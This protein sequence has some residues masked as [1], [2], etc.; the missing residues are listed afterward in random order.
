MSKSIELKFGVLGGGSISGQ[1][2]QTIASQINNIVNEIERRGITNL[3]F[4]VDP[5]A[6]KIIRTQLGAIG[7]TRNL[8]SGLDKLETR[9]NSLGKGF[10]NSNTQMARGAATALSEMKK[11][12]VDIERLRG[13]SNPSKSELSQLEQL[14]KQWAKNYSAVEKYISAVNKQ[15]AI[16]SDIE[17]KGDKSVSSAYNEAQQFYQYGSLGSNTAGAT[18]LNAKMTELNTTYSTYNS[19]LEKAQNKEL[20][21]DQEI[22][23]LD[24]CGIKIKSLSNEIRNLSMSASRDSRAGLTFGEM[25]SFSS[26]QRQAKAVANLKR[27]YGD[28]INKNAEL[29]SSF[30]QLEKSFTLNSAGNAYIGF[31]N[32]AKGAK[33]AS[34]AVNN[35]RTK[36]DEAGI[37]SQSFIYKTK[38][39]FTKH[40]STYIAMAGVTLAM[41]AFQQLYENV[42]NVDK[43]M[44]ELKKVTN[45]TNEAYN[46][47]LDSAIKKSQALGA[48]V[49]DYVNATADFAR[50]GYTI[51]ESDALA[52]A[53]TVYKNVGDGIESIDMASESIIATMKAFG[54]EAIEAMDIIDAFNEVGNNFAISSTGIGEAITRSASSLFT[55]GNTLAESIA[56]ITAAN[57]SVQDP[58]KVGTTLKTVTMFLRAAKDEAEDAGESTEGMA[59][60]VSELRDSLLH[61]TDNKVDIMIDDSTFKSTTQILRELSQVWDNLTDVDRANILEKI[62]GKRNSNVVSSLITNFETVEEVLATIQTDAGSAMAEQEKWLDSI[63]GKTNQFKSSFESLST[64]VLDS[65]LVKGIVS[66]GTTIINALDSVFGFMDGLLVKLPLV[67]VAVNLAGKALTAFLGSKFF[68][69]AL[70]SNFIQTL[71]TPLVGAINGVASAGLTA[72]GVFGGLAEGVKIAATSIKASLAAMGPVGWI[73]L[74]A[75]AVTVLISAFN[76]AKQKSE[77]A[78]QAAEESAKTYQDNANSLDEYSNKIISL[79]KELDAGNLSE[80]EAYNKRQELIEIQKDLIEKYGDESIAINTLTDDINEQ[81]EAFRT[82]KEEKWEDWKSSH[83]G[84]AQDAADVMTNPADKSS[85]LK[86]GNFYDNDRITYHG[87]DSKLTEKIM[88][89]VGMTLGVNPNDMSQTVLLF[90]AEDTDNIYSLIEAYQ[91]LFTIVE[92]YKNQVANSGGDTEPYDELLT[93]I[94]GM[95]SDLEAF[96]KENETNFNT[97]AEG[98][99]SFNKEY[100]KTWDKVVAAQKEYDDA[101][102]GGDEAEILSAIEKMNAAE[103]AFSKITVNDEAVALYAKRYFEKFN[104]ETEKYQV[105]LNLI[106]DDKQVADEAKKACDVF[107]NEAGKIDKYEI[108]NVELELESN[109]NSNKYSENKE[110][111]YKALKKAADEY[112]IEVADLIDILAE[113]GLI[114]LTTTE[115]NNNLEKSFSKTISTLDSMSG[116]GSSINSI[117][118]SMVGGEGLQFNDLSNLTDQMSEFEMTTEE[119]DKY[120]KQV[121]DAQGSAAEMQQVF[122]DLTN[123]IIS[124]KIAAGELT[125]EHEDLLALYLKQCGVANATQVAH[126][127]LGGTITITKEEYEL[128]SDELKNQV[129]A[130]ETANG[131]YEIEAEVIEELGGTVDTMSQIIAL[132]QAGITDVTISNCQARVEALKKEAEA[133]LKIQA[134]IN[135]LNTAMPGLGNMYGT[136]GTLANTL[137]DKLGMGDYDVAGTGGMTY[138]EYQKSQKAAEQ[139]KIYEDALK[140]LSEITFDGGGGSNSGDPVLDAWNKSVAEQKHLLEMD[141]QTKEEYY[142]W[143]RDNYKKSLGDAEKYADEIRSIEEE[144]YNWEK[145]QIAE[146]VALKE[147]Q[148]KNDLLNGKKDEVEYQR[149][150]VDTYKDAY[151]EIEENANLYGVDEKERLDALNGYLDKEKSA[152]NALYEEERDLLEHKLA[153]NLISE[154]MYLIELTRLYNKYY[155]GQE[156]YAEE[157][158]EKREELF[159]KQN[160]VMEKWAQ[161]AADAVESIA[162]AAEDAVSAVTDLIEGSIDAHEENFNLEKGLLDHALAMNYIS[163]EEYYNSLESLYKKYF[164]DKYIYMEQYWENQEEVYQHEQEMLEESASAVED[165]HAKVVDMIKQELEDAIESIEEAKEKYLDLIDIRREALNEQ[166]DEEDY[167]KERDEQIANISELQRQ[168]NALANDTSAEGIRKYKEVY[169]Q[170][171]EAE[172]ALAEFEREHTYEQMNDELDNEA[173]AV[174]NRLDGKITEYEKL[175]DDNVYLVE[176]AWRRMS[177]MNTDLY[178]QLAEHNAKHTTSIKDDL[179]DAWNTATEAV[180]RYN[181][182]QTGYKTI[183]EQIG[184]PGMDSGEYDSYAGS[185]KTKQT[186]NWVEIAGTFGAEMLG[187]GTS[188]LT[189]FTGILDAIFDSPATKLLDMGAGALSAF[190]QS[191]AS[192]LTTILGLLGG[193]AGGTSYVPKTGMYL[194]DELGEELKLI[195]N[196]NGASYTMLTR[197]SKVITNEATER[198]MKLVSNPDLLTG[199]V[200]KIKVADVGGSIPTQTINNQPTSIQNTFYIQSNTPKE[201]ASEIEKLMPKIASYTIG[202]MVNGSNNLGIKRK[203]QHLY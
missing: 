89:E 16:V 22:A 25:E 2:G 188:L 198:L 56:L 80:Q 3:K 55:A 14:E 120:T 8:T 177:D 5:A 102:L 129:K 165:I 27:L 137:F 187:V 133:Y 12:I 128:L 201:V 21:S 78:R 48:S 18:A 179:T 72:T 125:S 196:P 104:K 111:S 11:S 150:L 117:M 87:L 170:L 44:T 103:D 197:G 92:T 202:S 182:A 183:L 24:D 126:E 13:L 122:S 113:L 34:T 40:F 140:E 109:P 134:L 164:K 118:E 88:N 59:N 36:L 68:T 162:Q 166:K 66:V 93:R 115:N 23:L 39:L 42:S 110:E 112:G 199:G 178:N 83:Y 19:L 73:A 31:Q 142:E 69:G 63:E 106:T 145:Q 41:Q 192:I 81:I 64:T 185:I 153:M 10:I 47:F 29:S 99:L 148:L 70:N 51:D 101:L 114:T 175:L 136:M 82:L 85:W 17:G 52:T 147:A 144:L 167:N 169:N 143:L 20:V 95:K 58:E 146:N 191:G 71:L 203:T 67:I 77:E 119:I 141:K 43:A 189:D 53:A 168:L 46:H 15:K 163:E 9:Y 131:A 54:M 94:S 62:G 45:E 107:K 26:I 105:K 184:Q 200:A 90:N 180:N 161:A 160:E 171:M 176:E 91:K 86:E 173:E 38:E 124:Q 195:K 158:M 97:W 28:Q 50:L 151:D 174:E 194:T 33:M 138:E 35:F 30:S 4:A 123:D 100:S 116:V 108:L 121:L 57:S 181:D 186:F 172:D 154:E 37:V 130:V 159:K 132:A 190:T 61:L 79:R 7:D 157:D 139:I 1:S 65:S 84:A 98:Q 49:A 32:T 75:S 156:K 74:A 155:A 152:Y 193:F 76:S 96:Q 6:L 149:E 135:G 127:R 60:S